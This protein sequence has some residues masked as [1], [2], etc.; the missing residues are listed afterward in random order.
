MI[1]S[2]I[3][4]ARQL[5]DHY[6]GEALADA[7]PTT[8]EHYRV[9]VSV[10]SKFLER[11]AVVSDLNRETIQRFTTY[12]IDTKGRSVV[13]ADDYRRKLNRLARFAEWLKA[14]N[15]TLFRLGAQETNQ[16]FD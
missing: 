16:G 7:A 6:I 5:A 8:A 3:A 9:A 10:L 15:L 4:T 11:V 13:T 14:K 1:A 2:T 12:W